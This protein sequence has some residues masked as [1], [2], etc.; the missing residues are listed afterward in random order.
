MCCFLLAANC[1]FFGCVAS[2]LQ[3]HASFFRRSKT[4]SQQLKEIERDIDIIQ[5]R[6]CSA[7]LLP[8]VINR[9]QLDKRCS[10]LIYVVDALANF[11]VFL[12]FQFSI[13]CHLLHCM[14]L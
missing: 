1:R 10:N 2:L 5:A 4:R 13:I 6:C 7:L 3:I 8:K 14:S 9:P 12:S 11:F